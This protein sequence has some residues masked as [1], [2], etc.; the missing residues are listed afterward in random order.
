MSS[1]SYLPSAAERSLDRPWGTLPPGED[2]GRALTA[3]DRP[4]GKVIVKI[5]CP[6]CK[7]LVDA[8]VYDAPPRPLLYGPGPVYFSLL[9]LARTSARVARTGAAKEA[10]GGRR[11]PYAGMAGILVELAPFIA[12]AAGRPYVLGSAGIVEPVLLWGH[13]HGGPT[14]GGSVGMDELLAKVERYRATGR[15]QEIVPTNVHPPPGRLRVSAHPDGA[16]HM[17]PSRDY[18]GPIGT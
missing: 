9:P 15:R 3:A 4:A 18:G 8:A 5:S 6:H 2:P 14:T 1:W 17:R 11:V 13:A 12:S 7:K 10:E 16:P